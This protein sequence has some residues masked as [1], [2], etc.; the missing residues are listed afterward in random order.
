MVNLVAYTKI[1]LKNRAKYPLPFSKYVINYK[2]GDEQNNTP[3]NLELIPKKGNEGIHERSQ[4]KSTIS[5]GR[6]K[7][8]GLMKTQVRRYRGKR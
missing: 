7:S 1:Y 6:I 5:K 4:P 8:E 3:K 2:D